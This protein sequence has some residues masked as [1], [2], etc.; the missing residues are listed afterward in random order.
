MKPRRQSIWPG[1]NAPPPAG[2][3]SA[4]ATMSVVARIGICFAVALVVVPIL[5][6]LCYAT[7][8]Q[9]SNAIVGSV[10]A[11]IVIAVWFWTGTK[12]QA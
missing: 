7:I 4:G 11:F 3:A 9:T 5:V 2:F 8:G 10:G 12:R 6:L 1:Q